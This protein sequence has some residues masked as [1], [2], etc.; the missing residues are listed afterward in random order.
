MKK[1][2]FKWGWMSE[3]SGS[4]INYAD[5]TFDLSDYHKQSMENEIF[6]RRIYEKFFDVEEG[7]IVF[8]VGASVGPFTYSI[9]HKNPFHV[10]CLE[11]S[12]EEFKILVQNTIGYPVTQINKGICGSNNFE[13]SN[14]IFTDQNDIDCITFETL[15]E[16][17]GI[18]NIDF[19]KIDCEG[20]EY[21]I[22]NQ[23]NLEWIK[24]NVKKISG[25]WHLNDAETKT[26]FRFF[27][28]NILNHF[29]NFKVFSVDGID[30]KWDL[31][32]NHFIDYYNEI[33]IYIINFQSNLDQV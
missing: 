5:Q 26:K 21:E 10:F 23:N 8:D 12:R 32:N 6:N 17:L 1:R 11:P 14:K 2:S 27:R 19:L 16:L 33:I 28:D 29:E 9:L 7:D 20:C 3:F 13:L 22:F 15:I 25:E 24:K 31:Y 18:N 30:I 4:K